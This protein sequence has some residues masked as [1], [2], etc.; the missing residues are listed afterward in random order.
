M[1][2]HDNLQVCLYALESWY[3]NHIVD[4]N[5]KILGQC[6]IPLAGWKASEGVEIL[7]MTAPQ[8][9]QARADMII[10][11]GECAIYLPDISTTTPLCIIHCQG[12][13]PPHIPDGEKWLRMK[14]PHFSPSAIGVSSPTYS[15]SYPIP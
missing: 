2:L 3:P 1:H 12:K 5:P 4:I 15:S 7:S 11:Y 14:Q 13:I 6:E 10:N 8:L 9:L